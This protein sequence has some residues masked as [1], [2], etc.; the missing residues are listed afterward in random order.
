MWYLENAKVTK[1]EI[2]NVM[3]SVC[4]CVIQKIQKLENQC[5][6]Y[7]MQKLKK[8]LSVVFENCRS[9]EKIEN[10]KVIKFVW[11]Y[12]IQKLGTLCGF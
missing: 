10:A 5:G 2:A 7:K 9:Y 6:F 1:I 11:F 3:I 12:K 4:V 8:K